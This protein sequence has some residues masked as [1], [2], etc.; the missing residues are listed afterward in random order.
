M[1][2][3]D[4]RLQWVL[5]PLTPTLFKGQLYMCIELKYIMYVFLWFAVKELE[6][7]SSRNGVL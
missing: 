3:A 1:L 2:Y 4:F 7:H 5:V 6:K